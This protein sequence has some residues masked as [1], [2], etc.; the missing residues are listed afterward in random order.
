MVCQEEC[1]SIECWKVPGHDFGRATMLMPFTSICMVHRWKEWPYSSLYMTSFLDP[2]VH[3][4]KICAKANSVLGFIACT[5]R[6]TLSLS[7]LKTLYI[8]LVWPIL[9]YCCKVW[10]LWTS[11]YGAE[12]FL[13]AFGSEKWHPVYQCGCAG[14]CWPSDPLAFIQKSSFWPCFAL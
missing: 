2:G 7:T 3:I 6:N 14:H 9:Y 8:S 10:A 11:Q 12:E 4:S 13:T 1:N 5:S